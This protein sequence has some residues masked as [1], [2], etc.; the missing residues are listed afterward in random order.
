MV[1][2]AMKKGL[3]LFELEAFDVESAEALLA[4]APDTYAY[5]EQRQARQTH[6]EQL[7][8]VPRSVRLRILEKLRYEVREPD[9]G[10]VLDVKSEMERP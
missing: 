10:R 6:E 5:D 2:N 4:Q 8:L 9:A 3:L 1:R 7:D